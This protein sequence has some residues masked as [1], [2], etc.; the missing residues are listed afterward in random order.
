[1]IESAQ[2]VILMQ[3]VA[4]QN[5]S[6]HPTDEGKLDNLI[7]AADAMNRSASTMGVLH[8]ATNCKF[9]FPWNNCAS[10]S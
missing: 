6:L 10:V 7:K 1:M 8:T 4:I 3:M 9:S 2:D 5:E